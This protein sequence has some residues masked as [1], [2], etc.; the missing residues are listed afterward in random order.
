MGLCDCVSAHLALQSFHSTRLERISNHHPGQ[1]P[2][3]VGVLDPAVVS[4]LVGLA[5]RVLG[6]LALILCI[7]LSLRLVVLCDV[8][9]GALFAFPKVAV[10]HH[11]VL[12]EGRIQT[13]SWEDKD[14]VKRY[15]TEIVA[16]HVQ[17]IG[18]RGDE[19]KQEAV[20]G[21]KREPEPVDDKPSLPGMD[22]DGSE[23]PF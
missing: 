1:I 8:L 12:V 6:S 9:L 3:R 4:L 14:G 19:R 17:F 18:G 7:A 10:A 13:S 22:D 23:F 11:F 16:H 2:V 5:L 20:P 15:K 21:V